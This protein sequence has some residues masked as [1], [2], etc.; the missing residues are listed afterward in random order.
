VGPDR[1]ALWIDRPA[2]IIRELAALAV[3]KIRELAA[4]AVKKS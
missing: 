1:F 2:P 3:K 4:L